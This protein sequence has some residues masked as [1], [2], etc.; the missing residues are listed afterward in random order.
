MFNSRIYFEFECDMSCEDGGEC[1]YYN[2]DTGKCEY[3]CNS[4]N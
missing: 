2:K 1:I 3:P 4:K